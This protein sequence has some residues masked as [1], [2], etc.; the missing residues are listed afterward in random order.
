MAIFSTISII[1]RE[2]LREP[3]T[4]VWN[5]F[6][7]AI[8]FALVNSKA[9]LGGER[10][11][12]DAIYAYVGFTVLS[13]SLYS[14]GIVLVDRRERGFFSSITQGRAATVR[15][16]FA[17]I[18]AVW[19]LLILSIGLLL[20][21]LG[22]IARSVTALQV[23][24]ALGGASIGYFCLAVLCGALVVFPITLRSSYTAASFVVLASLAPL[25]ISANLPAEVG[26]V[27]NLLDPILVVQS[28]MRLD[29]MASLSLWAA[30]FQLGLGL[31]ILLFSPSS[32]V[33]R[34]AI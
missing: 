16:L 29:S 4:F 33:R 12:F 1:L 30:L 18:L 15:Y 34:R 7:P 2:Q 26:R 8:V 20:F 6:V 28:L 10:L 13:Y 5:V 11:P 22:F 24:I 9:M 3:L 32:P 27:L 23:A 25:W 17:H 19:V 21:L 31:V 14:F